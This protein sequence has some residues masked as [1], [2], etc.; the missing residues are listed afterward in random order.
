M[1]TTSIDDVLMGAMSSQ[2]DSNFQPDEP[3]ESKP[4]QEPEHMNEPEP[5]TIEYESEP[6]Q[7]PES[8]E[9]VK[10]SVELDDYGN[11]KPKTE[12]KTYTEDEV[13]ERI[14]RAVRERLERIERNQQQPQQQQAQ[15]DFQYDSSSEQSWE[16]QLAA[17]VKQTVNS[18]S[19]EQKQAEQIQREQRIQQEFEMKFH[20]GMSKFSDFREVVGAQPISDAM[21]MATRAMSDPAAFIYAASK[22][23]PQELQRIANIPDQYAQMVEMG[24]LEERMRKAKATTNAPRPINHTRDESGFSM[25]KQDPKEPSIEDLMAQADERKLKKLRTFRGR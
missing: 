1:P 8:Q 19:Q 23:H 9:P 3:M 24:R 14:N 2:P 7:S 16:Q 20:Q 18:M 15:Q 6:E 12:T 4:S 13:N 5:E 11:E 21:T 17:F 25:A 10:E 22:R